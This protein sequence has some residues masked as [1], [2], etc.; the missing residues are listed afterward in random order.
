MICRPS[1]VASEIDWRRII[2]EKGRGI[3]AEAHEIVALERLRVGQNLERQRDAAHLGVEHKP[4][5]AH[6]LRYAFEGG[7]PR[8]HVIEIDDAAGEHD[9]RKQRAR[10]QQGQTQTQRGFW[11]RQGG[12]EEPMENG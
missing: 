4:R 12:H 2:L 9:E 1:R 11:G 8:P 7:V 6:D 5:C 3:G 10:H